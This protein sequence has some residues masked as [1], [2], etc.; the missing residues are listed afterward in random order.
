MRNLTSLSDLICSACIWLL[1][2]ISDDSP[3][4][5]LMSHPAGYTTAARLAVRKTTRNPNTLEE[6]CGVCW[7]LVIGV[8]TT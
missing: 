1:A 3:E 2:A 8:G 4:R 7:K 6:D 5:S